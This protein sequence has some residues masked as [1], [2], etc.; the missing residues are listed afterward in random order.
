MEPTHPIFRYRPGRCLCILLEKG[1]GGSG[2]AR[3]DRFCLRRYGCC[4]HL[5]PADPRHGAVRRGG[6]M[7]IPAGGH[8]LL[9]WYPISFGTGSSDPPPPPAKPAGGGPPHPTATLH[10]DGAGG[11]PPQH[12]RGNG[13]GSGLC[14]PSVRG[15]TDHHDGRPGLILGHRHPELPRGSHHLHASAGGGGGQGPGLCGGVCSPVRWNPWAP[16]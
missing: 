14:G 1:S 11:H 7:G 13:G 5:E 15:G 6:R 12:P 9:G 16:G 4:V 8:R 2:A 3:T 10:H